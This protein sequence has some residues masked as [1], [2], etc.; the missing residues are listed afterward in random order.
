MI[1]TMEQEFVAPSAPSPHDGAQFSQK[2]IINPV[3]QL[4]MLLHA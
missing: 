1:D 2:V 3:R 4:V